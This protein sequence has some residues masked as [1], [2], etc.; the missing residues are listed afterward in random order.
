MDPRI[1]VLSF[2]IAGVL[3]FFAHPAW[4]VVAAVCFV[5][6]LVHFARWLLS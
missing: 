6:Y 2:A 5:A 1:L 3:G 4:F